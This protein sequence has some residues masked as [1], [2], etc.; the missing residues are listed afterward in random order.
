MDGETDVD[1][2]IANNLWKH[3]RM[4]PPGSRFRQYWDYGILLLVLY[5]C[6][7]TPMQFGFSLG[8][9]FVDSAAPL[10]AVDGAVW[11]VLAADVVINFRTSFYDDDH[12]IVLSASKV[13]QRYRQ[14]WFSWDM[15]GTVPYHV[16]AMFAAMECSLLLSLNLVALACSHLLICLRACP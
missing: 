16:A 11:L 5:N 1:R 10:L 13:A 3:H 14:G 7:L 12:Q 8:P 6:I 9:V 15:F 4:L 2:E